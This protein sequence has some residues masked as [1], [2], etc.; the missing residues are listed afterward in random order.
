LL[1]DVLGCAVSKY[2][3]ST[4]SAEEIDWFGVESEQIDAQVSKISEYCNQCKRDN[5]EPSKPAN[6]LE[7]GIEGKSLNVS[8][9]G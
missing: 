1:A 3:V 2:S 5:L 9:V 7:S 4:I 8:T 6:L